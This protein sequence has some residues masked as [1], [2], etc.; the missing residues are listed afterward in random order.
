MIMKIL[1][2]IIA[3]IAKQVWFVPNAF[4]GS[5]GRCI[6]RKTFPFLL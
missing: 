6:P 1:L 5:E 4:E 3:G 2:R